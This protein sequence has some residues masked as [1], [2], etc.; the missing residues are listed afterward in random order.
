[1]TEHVRYMRVISGILL[2]STY[3]NRTGRVSFITYLFTAIKLR[4]NIFVCMRTWQG[5]W[6]LSKALECSQQLLNAPDMLPRHKEP[7]AV[8][9]R[10]LSQED[11]PLLDLNIRFPSARKSDIFRQRLRG[12]AGPGWMD[13][14]YISEMWT[15]AWMSCLSGSKCPLNVMKFPAQKHNC[16]A[17]DAPSSDAVRSMNSARWWGRGRQRT[18]GIL[19]PRIV[20]WEEVVP[21][22]KC[23]CL[24]ID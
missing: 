10:A 20:Q 23:L 1:M 12:V 22:N 16:K 21:G 9:A 5:Y 7:N 14:V 6:M 19:L 11:S 24:T 3:F 4:N 2:C 15:S 13:D 18:L 8:H 17:A